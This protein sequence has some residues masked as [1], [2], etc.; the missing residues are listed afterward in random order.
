MSKQIIKQ[1]NGKYLIYNT[2]C[3][4]VTHY[5]LDKQG[6]IK[7]ILAENEEEIKKE[8]ELILND[9]ENGGLPYFQFT[10]DYEKMIALIE[11]MHGKQESERVNKIITE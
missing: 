9:L 11:M 5:N 8:I 10:M 3:E 4:N 1:P 7:Q 2:I 6:L